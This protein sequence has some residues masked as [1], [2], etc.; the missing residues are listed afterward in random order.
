MKEND[1]KEVARIG[2]RLTIT[3]RGNLRIEASSHSKN[4]TGIMGIFQIL[5]ALDFLGK[6]YPIAIV[7]LYHS[8]LPEQRGLIPIHIISDKE[9]M[10]G[11]Q[12]PMC[13]KTFRMTQCSYQCFCPY[14][15]FED[16]NMRFLT[17]KQKMYSE[18]YINLFVQSQQRKEDF[19]IDLTEVTESPLKYCE[20]SEQSTY[21]C[22]N[23]K[24]QFNIEGVY[25]FC[26]NCGHRNSKQVVNK[27]LDNLLDSINNPPYDPD[28]Y[29]EKYNEELLN[30]VE[31]CVSHFQG[32]ANDIRKQ[33]SMLPMT[34]KRRK[35]I[36][37]INFQ[38]LDVARDELFELID[39]NLYKSMT[40][41]G[42][43]KIE[44]YF[45][46]RHVINKKN[47]VIDEDYQ[48]RTNDP[49][50]DYA[51]GKLVR[52]DKQLVCEMISLTKD[53]INNLYEGYLSICSIDN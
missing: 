2:D 39:I 35:S 16:S 20:I 13:K 50:P 21:E 4:G 38:H 31:K 36:L 12:C 22:E 10:F 27:L 25:G 23:C 34:P 26:P 8:P 24:I 15:G 19:A 53:L 48:R 47:S 44:K 41:N 14:C 5:V 45:C 1:Y 3:A 32:F 30:A 33:I 51:V 49:N 42:I 6:A 11:R 28:I 7:P 37:S 9:G 18:E 29:K 46:L 17:E 52:G 40:K 43:Y